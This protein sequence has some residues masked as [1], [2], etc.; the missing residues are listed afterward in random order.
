MELFVKCFFYYIAAQIKRGRVIRT[1]GEST[2][3]DTTKG[4][5]LSKGNLHV[6]FH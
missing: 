1:V 2:A 3:L 4:L 6:T 5:V